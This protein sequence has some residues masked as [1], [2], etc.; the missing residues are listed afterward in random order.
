LK[1]HGGIFWIEGAVVYLALVAL[2]I[3]F[4]FRTPYLPEVDSYYH[5]KMAY[6]MRTQHWVW[7]GFPWAQFS[8]WKDEFSDGCFLFHVILMPFTF[9]NDLALGGKLAIVVL[10]SASF[11]SLFLV[12]KLNR[13]RYPYYWLLIALL[14]G[15][16]FIW[17]MGVLRPQILST[18]LMMGAVHFLIQKKERSFAVVNFIYALSY[19]ASFIPLFFA[20]GVWATAPKAERKSA[21]RLFVFG[22]CAQALAF[23]VHPYF[24]KNLR[25]FFVQNIYVMYLAVSQSVNLY[26]GGEFFPFDTRQLLLAHFVIIAHLILIL[27]LSWRKGSALSSE[28]KKV[29]FFSALLWGMTFISKRFTEYAVPISVLFFAL[30]WRDLLPAFSF[31]SAYKK[32]RKV[33]VWGSVLWLVIIGPRIFRNTLLSIQDFSH[34]H[35]SRFEKAIP[36]IH[37][38]TAPLETVYTCDWDNAPELF[39]FDHSRQYLVMMDPT[40]MYYWNPEIWKKWFQISNA[41]ISAD[42]I[43]HELSQTFKTRV[44]VCPQFFMAFKG[45]VLQDKRFRLLYEDPQVFVFSLGNAP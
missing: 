11:T 41:Q 14:G 17:R 22:L 20:G 4:Q 24:P 27:S 30:A 29:F 6:L 9:F 43:V 16:F 28:S 12:L 2:W 45:I 3:L 25:F 26:L 21:A 44:G 33:F 37:Q 32:S 38:A 1:K 36:I 35:A 15:E 13:V 42:Q 8:L 34:V 31:Q 23:V 5:I 7:H 18:M 40:F 10:S 39:Y 19:V